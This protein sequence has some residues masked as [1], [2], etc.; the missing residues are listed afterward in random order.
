MKYL[1]SDL[2]PSDIAPIF[3]RFPFLIESVFNAPVPVY[4]NDIVSAF[5]THI[6]LNKVSSS[7]GN[8]SITST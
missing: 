5:L 8:D 4:T 3:V 7:I 6:S 1:R 2:Y